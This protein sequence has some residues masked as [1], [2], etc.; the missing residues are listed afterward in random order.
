MQRKTYA[1]IDGEVLKENV[2]EIKKKYPEYEY[3]IGVVKN[4]A[5]HHGIKCV[6]DFVDGGVNYLAVSSLEEA[7]EIRNYQR[8]IPILCLE[9]IPLEYID[10]VLN[11]SVTITVDSL[12]YLKELERQDV[13]CELKRIY[14]RK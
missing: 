11:A 5:Y 6:L 2:E 12:D 14:E 13:Y 1:V 8:E 7:L 9:P 3:Y 4:N 10:D